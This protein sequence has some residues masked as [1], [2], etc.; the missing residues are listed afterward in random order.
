[1]VRQEWKAL[2]CERL[3]CPPADYE[4]RA[5]T[6]CLYGH[7]RLLAPVIRWL[8][9]D[10]FAEDLKLIQELG[11]ASDWQEAHS[12]ISTFQ[13]ANRATRS[14]WR[15]GLRIRVSGRKAAVLAQQLFSKQRKDGAKP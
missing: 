3:N 2:F 12:E 14:L 13:D 4:D 10:F 7:A 8:S 6:Q 11:M 15:T 9:P 1:M 5:F